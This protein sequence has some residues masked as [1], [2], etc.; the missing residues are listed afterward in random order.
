MTCARA[1]SIACA[2]RPDGATWRASCSA[3]LSKL[4]RWN[5]VARGLTRPPNFQRPA[6]AHRGITRVF[7][8]ASRCA[9]SD[10][11]GER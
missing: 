1:A 6:L 9:G 8:C 2:S 7:D 10:S 3:Q 11:S 4:R 5:V